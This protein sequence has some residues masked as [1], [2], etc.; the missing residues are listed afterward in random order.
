MNGISKFDPSYI[1]D[2]PQNEKRIEQLCNA[3]AAELLM[4]STDFDRQVQA[5]ARVTDESIRSLANRYRVSREVVLRRLT[6]KDLWH[7]KDGVSESD[8]REDKA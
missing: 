5:V 1:D 4:P 2:L 7:S 8:E 3:F 6:S